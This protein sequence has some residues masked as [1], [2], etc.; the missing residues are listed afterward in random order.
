MVSERTKFFL[1]IPDFWPD[2]FGEEYSLL[3]IKL[4]TEERIRQIRTA[5]KRVGQIYRKTLPLLQNMEDDS[6]LQLGIPEEAIPYVRLNTSQLMTL[7]GRMDFVVTENDIKLLEFNTDT[8]TFMKETF[9]VNGRVSAYFKERDANEGLEQLLMKSLQRGI[10]EA[11]Q[12]TE[13][14]SPIIVFTSHEDHPEDY[15]TT[16]YL[17]ELCDL[18]SHF[19]P[20]SKLKVLA[21][22]IVDNGKLV[23]KRGAYT[24]DGERID[25]LYR[26]T[27]PIEHLIDDREVTTKERV[28]VKL[29]R[30]VEEEM[31][32]LLN[33]PSAFLLQ[34]KAVQAVIW[35]LHQEKQAFFSL[36]EHGWIQDYFLPTYLEEEPFLVKKEQFVRKPAFGRE[37][38]SIVIFNENGKKVVEDKQKTYTSALSVF[39]KFANLPQYTIQTAKGKKKVH[40]LYG[41]FYVHNMPMAIGIRAGGLI[42]DNHSYFLP[43]GI[44][45]E[46]RL[47]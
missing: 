47:T 1:T 26:P 8:P 7:I 25:V 11:C 24:P 36:E 35:G 45:D 32:I 20:L 29:L 27:Y 37:G 9:H 39:Q 34:S 22:D 23:L 15:Y 19:I 30:L 46:R 18:P 41:C 28:G 14:L 42:T 4:E 3:D 33:P 13:T 31:L 21:E 10:L 40:L 16:K 6:L 12:R 2:L 5:S 38:D 43:I 44:Q 17:Q